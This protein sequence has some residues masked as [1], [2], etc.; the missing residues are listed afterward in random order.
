[1]EERLSVYTYHRNS[2]FIHLVALDWKKVSIKEL[3]AKL[4]L[5]QRW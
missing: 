3:L 4:L 1:M 2:D 5:T